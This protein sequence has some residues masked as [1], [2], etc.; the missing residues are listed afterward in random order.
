MSNTQEFSYYFR[1]YPLVRVAIFCGILLIAFFAYITVILVTRKVPEITEIN[2]PV[3]SS[4]ETISITGRNFGGMK[5]D[6]YVEINGNRITPSAY[7][8]WTDTEIKL[9]LPFNTNDGLLYV[10]TNSGKSAPMVYTSKETIPI[11]VET[12]ESVPQP[13]ILYISEKKVETGTAVTISGNNFGTLRNGSSVFFQAQ[14][15]KT[16]SDEVIAACDFDRDYIFW[17]NQEITVRVPDG[18]DSGWVYV[19][20]PAGN[21]NRKRLEISRTNGKKNYSDKHSYVLSVKSEI[22]DINASDNTVLTV[23]LPYP[24]ESASQ[25]KIEAK[26]FVPEPAIKKI[27]GTGSSGT[28][29]YQLPVKKGNTDLI[30]LE[31]KFSATVWKTETEITAKDRKNSKLTDGYYSRLLK[32]DKIVPADAAEIKNLAAS[33]VKKENSVWKKAELI[34]KYLIKNFELIKD[35]KPSDSL[36][37]DVLETGAADAYDFSILFAAL[38]RAAGIPTVP[39]AG[40]IAGSDLKTRNHWWN[41]FYMEGIG[42]IPVDVSMG[43]GLEY[44]LLDKAEDAA[45]FYFGNIDSA[46]IAFSRGL[47][48]IKSAKQAETKVCRERVYSLQTVWEEAAS[49]IQSFRNKWNPIEIEA[50]F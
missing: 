17:S 27:Q 26:S 24:A 13:E 43:A 28:V 22:K 25:R 9:V 32:A 11:A 33:I 6:S 44:E 7:T 19:S 38:S 23:F 48:T 42:W 39:V 35:F 10:K 4:G 50:V 41:E 47:N 16:R 2:P 29:F 3:S 15:E 1:K 37:M 5:I 21:S 34:Y 49:D 30:A 18:A 40:I 12:E 45:N 31:N 46:H 36:V 8:L 20:T 14:T